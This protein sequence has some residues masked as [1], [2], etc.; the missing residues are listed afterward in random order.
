MPRAWNAGSAPML[1]LRV[2]EPDENSSPLLTILAAFRRQPMNGA[3]RSAAP[4]PEQD[5]ATPAVRVPAPFRRVYGR[6]CGRDLHRKSHQRD[7]SKTAK[8]ARPARLT[9]IGVAGTPM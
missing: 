3:R 2:L 4:A 1:K 5:H 6:K 7:C 9:R 8:T